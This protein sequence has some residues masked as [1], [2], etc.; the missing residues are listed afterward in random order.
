[1]VCVL[2]AW[3]DGMGVMDDAGVDR[4]PR[5]IMS[6][7]KPNCFSRNFVPNLDDVMSYAVDPYY[8]NGVFSSGSCYPPD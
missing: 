7:S 4:A 2:A 3:D 1:M 8:V 6:K 5:N